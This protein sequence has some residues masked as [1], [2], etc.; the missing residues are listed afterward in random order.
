MCELSIDWGVH[1]RCV[2]RRTPVRTAV[3][4]EGSRS[5]PN[6]TKPTYQPLLTHTEID[7]EIDARRRSHQR[8]VAAA[9]RDGN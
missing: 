5:K 4:G 3:E 2:A 9:D 8:H 7:L 6:Q 1:G